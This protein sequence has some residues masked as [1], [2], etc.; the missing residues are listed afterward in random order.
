MSEAPYIPFYTS[1]FLGGT[2]GMTAATKGVYITLLCLMYEAEG[3]LAQKWDTLARRCGCTLPAFKRAVQDLVDDGKIVILND[4]IWSE[5]C[6]KHLAQRRERRS[7]AKAAAEKRWQKDKQKQGEGDAPASSAHCQPEPEPEPY[8]KEEEPNGS[9]SSGDDATKPFDEIAQAVS[10]YNVAAE[11]AGWPQVKILSTSRRSA[12]KARLKECGG[13][14][15]WHAALEKAQSSPHLTGQNDRGWT[16]SFDFL[17]RQSSFAK[18]MEGNYD[19]KPRNSAGGP[20][21]MQQ[22]R[23]DP[24]LEQIARLAGLNQAS[25]TGRG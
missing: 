25:G 1:D 2:S 16:A 9:L 4:G 14:E 15:G 12:L 21:H 5:K 11:S 22:N 13:I 8:K 20:A 3:P 24:A 17:T 19:A 6:E 23:P 18:L 7:S 10:A